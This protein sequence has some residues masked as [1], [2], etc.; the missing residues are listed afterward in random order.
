[1][2]NYINK[3]IDSV[4]KV[5][6]LTQYLRGHKGFI[7]GGCFKNIFKK[8]K[9]KDI[10]VF[11][12]N[13]DEFD[14]AVEYYEEFFGSPYYENEKV[15]AF[16]LRNG[17]IIE[18]I[19]YTFG[20]PEEILNKFDFSITKFALYS[21][22][23]LIDELLSE[24]KIDTTFEVIYHNDF[25]E[26]LITNKLVLEKEILFPISTFE[27][28]LRYTKYGYGLCQESKVN[29]LSSILEK[30]NLDGLSIELYNGLD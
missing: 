23:K 6:F 4:N 21:K 24:E 25:F 16:K 30:G 11:F 7:A 13:E 15:V 20:T 22:P 19:K 26:H 18:L 10:D 3:N 5:K 9:L 27:R 29:L 28:T 2:K 1:M 8:E 14:E 17:L 12:K